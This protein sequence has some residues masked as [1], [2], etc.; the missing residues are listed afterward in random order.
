MKTQLT[1][2]S[3][4]VLGILDESFFAHALDCQDIDHA[5]FVIKSD[6]CLGQLST[7]L[8]FVKRNDCYYGVN[9]GHLLFEVMLKEQPGG[10]ALYKITDN[11]FKQVES[12]L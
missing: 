12:S 1:P 9:K 5:G 3:Q 8:D 6:Y 10:F 7:K 11:G 2:Q 4:A